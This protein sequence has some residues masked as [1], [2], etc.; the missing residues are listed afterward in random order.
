MTVREALDNNRRRLAGK[1]ESLDLL[2]GGL[3]IYDV[4]EGA[5]DRIGYADPDDF[6][7]VRGISQQEAREEA[8]YFGVPL[9]DGTVG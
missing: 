6:E 7:W 4:T 8:A 5:D 1:L 9:K 2:P 3:L